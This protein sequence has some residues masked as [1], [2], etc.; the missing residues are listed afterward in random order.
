MAAYFKTDVPSINGRKQRAKM[1][2]FLHILLQYLEIAD[3]LKV[4]DVKQIIHDSVQ[5]NRSGEPGT[6][7]LQ[8][9]LLCRI[10]NHTGPGH[11]ELAGS[12]FH[13]FIETKTLQ[14]KERL[15][16]ERR[17]LFAKKRPPQLAGSVQNILSFPI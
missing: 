14:Q 1:V 8:V 5:R 11:W 4:Q 9:Y 7:P 12:L 2:I 16:Q 13:K 15:L 3:P 17:L 10:K 6:S